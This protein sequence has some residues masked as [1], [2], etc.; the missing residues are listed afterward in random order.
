MTPRR[1][2]RSR[3]TPPYLGPTPPRWRGVSGRPAARWPAGSISSR[4]VMAAW[5]FCVLWSLI[6]NTA[7]E[8]D[9]VAVP[10]G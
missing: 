2:S 10:S 3:R 6:Y 8:H 1:T 7:R 4:S 9:M 5:A